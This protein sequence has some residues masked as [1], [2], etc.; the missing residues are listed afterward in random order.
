[1]RTIGLI[2][3]MSWE[4]TALYY[5]WINEAVRDARGANHSAPLLL[6]SFDFEPIKAMQMR[7]EWEAMGE[8][9]ARAAQGLERAGAE[10]IVICT[11]TMHKLAGEVSAAVSV[12]LIH[13]ADATARAI[14]EAGHD[15]VALL[16]TRFTM[17]ER[18]Y[19]ERLE[20]HGLEVLVPSH[21]RLGELNRIIY[22]E[23]CCGSVLPQSRETYRA[24]IGDLVA[25]G[26]QAVI[27]GCTELTMLLGAADSPVPLF[28]TTA[29]HARAAADFVLGD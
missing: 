1:M 16:G 17:E 14:G 21:D 2:G 23:L 5:R 6:H 8:L 22:D 11:N 3:G 9:L 4:S 25:Q 26:A 29:I 19:R 7:G 27:L 12:P 10:A 28:D 15:K 13:L 18:F 20:G 24:T